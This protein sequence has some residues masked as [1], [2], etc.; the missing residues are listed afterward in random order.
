MVKNEETVIRA[1]LQPF[2]DGGIDSFFV[3]D[4]GST[5]R[6][7]EVVQKFFAE[8]SLE[9]AYIAQE[10][11]IDFAASRNRALDLAQE[12]FPCAAFMLMIDA[13]WYINNARAL[14][15]FCQACLQRG[16]MYPSYLVRIINEAFDNYVCRL[17]RCNYEVRFAGVVHETVAQQTQ[18]K[19]PKNIFFEY[20]PAVI[21]V[22]ASKARFVRDRELLY[23]EYQKNPCD[24]R[25]LFYLARAC[26]ALDDLEVAYNFYKKR[27][28]MTGFDEEDF[29][30]HYR[31][32]E[33][34]KQLILKKS[35]KE[36]QWS[37]ALTYYIKAYQMRP[38]RA[39]PLIAIAD[40]YVT[41]GQMYWAYLY[42]RHAVELEYPVKDFL[43]VESYLYNFYRY[44]LLAHCIDYSRISL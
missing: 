18:I 7:V 42:V 36:Y 34:I 33:T 26:E 3:F 22:E 21:G 17:I 43:F 24:T 1:T 8:Y 15:D 41:I 16:D 29:M 5:D 44:K 31:L 6:T 12:K 13:E 37:E 28:V 39:E 4:T 9:K 23:K 2:I 35:D 14:V 38:H 19:V 27:V 25:T 32:A 40:Y 30:A 20:L 10:P 11:F